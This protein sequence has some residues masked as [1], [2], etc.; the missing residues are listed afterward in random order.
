MSLPLVMTIEDID[1]SAISYSLPVGLTISNYENGDED[2]WSGLQATTDSFDSD[3]AALAH[4]NESFGEE[5]IDLKNRCYF[6]HSM[7]Q[8]YIGTAMAWMAEEPFDMQ[9]GR[10]HWVVIHPR[11]RGLGLGKVLIRYTMQQLLRYTDKFYLTSQTSSLTAIDIY[12]DLGFRP[13]V[14]NS[15]DREA[16]E[17]VKKSLKDRSTA[18]LV[19]V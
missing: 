12:L 15:L 18:K 3:R 7:D 9:Y 10:L 11:Y 2:H 13:L 17:L 19:D 8:K 1:R 16:W 14:R 4:F 5:K 6:L